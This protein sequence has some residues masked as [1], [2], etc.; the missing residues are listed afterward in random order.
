MKM[1]TMETSVKVGM[2]FG[3]LRATLHNVGLDEVPLLRGIAK[4]ISLLGGVQSLLEEE[5]LQFLYSN[6]NFLYGALYNNTREYISNYLK[7][8]LI[9]DSDHKSYNKK[10]ISLCSKEYNDS[11]PEHQSK[12]LD[13][14]CVKHN[15]TNEGVFPNTSHSDFE[16]VCVI[17]GDQELCS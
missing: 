9:D 10:I 11:L 7:K 3:T 2:I 13:I 4:I 15:S 1:P 12:L 14:I 8:S 5:E 6:S 16:T 17:L